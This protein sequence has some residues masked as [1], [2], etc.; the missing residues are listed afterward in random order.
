MQFALGKPLME[1]TGVGVYCHSFQRNV[2]NLHWLV[3]ILSITICNQLASQVVLT[4]G[5]T[6]EMFLNKNSFVTY[7]ES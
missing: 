2:W 3:K 1:N 5:V 6:A 7:L 4:K